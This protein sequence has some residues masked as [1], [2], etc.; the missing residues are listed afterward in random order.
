MYRFRPVHI[1]I[2]VAL[3]RDMNS[4]VGKIAVRAFQKHILCW[5]FVRYW[6][7]YG[8]VFEPRF[9]QPRVVS[10]YILVTKSNPADVIAQN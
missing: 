7:R 10:S 4:T 8:G 2:R 6:S 3:D 1:R 9:L 5:G